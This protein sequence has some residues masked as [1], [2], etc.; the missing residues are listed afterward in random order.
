MHHGFTCKDE[1][2][3]ESRNLQKKEELV[4]IRVENSESLVQTNNERAVPKEYNS[5]DNI[6][7][8]RDAASHVCI[9]RLAGCVRDHFAH[10]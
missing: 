7:M 5:N 2:N 1:R 8:S 4:C 10:C 9:C 3:K 6:R